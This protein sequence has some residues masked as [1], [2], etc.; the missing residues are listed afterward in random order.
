[1]SQ[2]WRVNPV[3]SSVFS[4]FLIDIFFCFIIQYFVDYELGLFICF[5]LFYIKLFQSHDS[6]Q[7]FYELTQV[8]FDHFI[9]SLSPPDSW[10]HDWHIDKVSL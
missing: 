2:V 6:N 9:V 10:I 5:G 8:N 1:M 4:I 3:E 7:E